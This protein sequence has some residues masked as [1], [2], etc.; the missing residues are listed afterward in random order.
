VAKGF[1][2]KDSI[3]KEFVVAIPQTAVS[4]VVPTKEKRSGIG[5]SSPLFTSSTR[6]K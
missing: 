4:A 2:S 5:I 1:I 6:E 3:V